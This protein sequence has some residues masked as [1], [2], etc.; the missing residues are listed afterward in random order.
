[1]KVKNLILGL[2]VAFAGFAS[3]GEANAQKTFEKGTQTASLM[4]GLPSTTGLFSS[5]VVPPLTAVYERG[6][7]SN[8]FGNGKGTIGVGGQGEYVL[9]RA[10]PEVY[11]GYFFLGAR[12][13]LH[14]E[15]VPK[16]DTYAGL[17]LGWSFVGGTVVQNSGA[18]AVP[19]FVGA[20][21]YVTPTLALGGELGYGLTLVNLGVT[22]RF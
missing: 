20:R 12:G 13:A 7:V 16:L 4:I 19:F 21:Y 22:Y 14:Y 9:Y 15:F 3:L 5:I 11:S 10:A 1:M 18:F 8:L 6:V 2:A 17:A